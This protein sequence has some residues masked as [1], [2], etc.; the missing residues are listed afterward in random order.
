MMKRIGLV[1]IAFIL[2]TL[3]GYRS[4]ALA[5]YTM[6]LQTVGTLPQGTLIGA[7][8]LEITVPTGVEPIQGAQAGSVVATTS[9]MA[10]NAIVAASYNP[11][12]RIVGIGLITDSPF[13]IGQFLTINFTTTTSVTSRDFTVHLIEIDNT[14]GAKIANIGIGSVTANLS[15]AFSGLGAGT[16]TSVTPAIS[17]NSNLTQP[18]DFGLNIALHPAPAEFSLFSGWTGACSGTGDCLLAMTAA[19]SVT[20]TFAKNPDRV[21]ISGATP[22]YFPDIQSAYASAA[23]GNTIQVWGTDFTGPLNFTTN[24]AVTLKGGYNGVWTANTGYS[25]VTGAMTVGLG[26]VTIE[27]VT[28]K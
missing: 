14:A 13:G 15:I 7:I 8:Q 28:L 9:G 27:R 24:K 17:T 5:D 4:N 26:V 21:R 10:T 23:P 19:R 3:A 2:V 16:V 22:V 12:T 20:T 18:I 25:A 11:T 1:C 6:Y